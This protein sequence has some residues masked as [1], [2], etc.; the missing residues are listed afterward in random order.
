[1][2]SESRRPSRWT[3]Q[4]VLIA[5]LVIA[6]FLRVEYLRELILSP[7]GRNLLLDAEWYDQA[8]RRLAE[9][10]SF[11]PG[12]AYFRPPLYPMFLAG[13]HRVLGSG[14][15]GPRIVQMLLGLAQVWMCWRIA[16]IT[17]GPRVAQVAAVLA[18][19]YG[20]FIYFEGEILTTALGTA[21]TTAAAWLLLEGS[22]HR[23]DDVSL[24]L[25]FGGG[26]A[27]GLAAVTHATAL[28]LAPVAIL[29]ALRDRRG[30]VAAVVVLIGVLL[31]VGGVTARNARVAGEFVPV[32]S[33]GG[34][35]FYIG[36]NASSDGK[37]ALAPGFAE[38][39]Q[40][41]RHDDVYRDTVEVA[42]RTLAEREL[43]RPLSANE[44]SRYWYEKGFDWFRERP[45]DALK[46]Q[47]QKVVFFWNGFEISNNRD[48]RDQARRFTPILRFFLVHF[49]LLLPFGVYGLFLS[50]F[51]RRERILLF[52]FLLAYTAAI[53]AFFVCARYR[54]PAVAWLIPFSAAGMLSIVDHLK[55]A[56]TAP[57]R[58]G[59]AAAILVLLFVFTS[60]RL[61]TRSGIADVTSENDAPFHRFNL[62]VLYEREGN[63]DRAIAEYRAAAAS[64]VP[65]PRIHLNLGNALARTGRGEDARREYR[66]VLRLA[67]DYA[68]A[69]RSNLGILAAQAGDWEEAIRQFEECL[70]E[71]PRHEQALI[72]LASSYLRSGRF[73]EAIV[74][75][76]RALAARAGPEV[77]LRRS[78]G[79]AYLEMGLL[80]DAEREVRTALRLA[81]QDVT[82]FFTLARIYA[83]MD[84]PATAERM[85][86]KALELEPNAPAVAAAV[87]TLRTEMRQRA[88]GS[89]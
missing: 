76:R 33:Q 40:V 41:I 20:M 44:I 86:E 57:R 43:G 8:A 74:A 34:I 17:H 51:W 73:D 37:S 10:S 71:A 46:H 25:S 15:I 7:F 29:W 36:N 66:E 18:G 72:G 13:L 22:R 6:V 4:P 59:I 61:V 79:V 65:D 24:A 23:S 67:P 48:L 5:A 30:L 3:A 64:G 53:A 47:F 87:E 21:L 81:P 26:F 1:M 84:D 14:L 62:A 31:P 68:A 78:L 85:C 49:A 80:E 32:G 11:S 12:E 69:V 28:A 63:L 77:E 16:R 89:P 35:N 19:T 42:A 38:A 70:L 55:G 60:G 75:Y 83:A 45:A 50:G 2:S 56:A 39:G 88:G 54:Q 27:I 9:G 52:G 82:T 58:A